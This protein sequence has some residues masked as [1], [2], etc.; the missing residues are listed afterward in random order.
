M[1]SRI[2]STKS[3]PFRVTTFCTSLTNSTSLLPQ[4]YNC[5]Y[6]GSRR[7]LETLLLWLQKHTDLREYDFG[8]PPGFILQPKLANVAY[9]CSWG[10]PRINV[11]ISVSW[12]IYKRVWSTSYCVFFLHGLNTKPINRKR[13]KQK[14]TQQQQEV[15]TQRNKWVTFT[16]F[17]SLVRRVTNLFRRTRLRIVF[18]GT[19]TIQQ[20]LNTAKHAG[21]DPSGIYKL[22]C[23]TC[24][25]VYVGQSGWTIGVRLKEHIRYIKSNN[26][27][28]TYAIHILENK[29]E[30]NVK[31]IQY[32]V[33]HNLVLDGILVY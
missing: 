5:R 27:T 30:S 28:S 17:S 20:Q 18:R 33:R 19:N 23:S 1:Y 22:K 12:K 21:D 15:I 6:Y 29:H 31:C 3:R 14:Q 2:T 7:L 24:N 4:S 9:A 16:Y 26:F 11:T 10:L 32:D 13:Q 25:K 8:H